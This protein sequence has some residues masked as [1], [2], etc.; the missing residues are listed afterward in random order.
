MFREWVIALDRAMSAVSFVDS[1]QISYTLLFTLFISGTILL[2]LS[3]LCSL[4]TFITA[5]EQI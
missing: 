5:F 3:S 4:S 2:E 1:L